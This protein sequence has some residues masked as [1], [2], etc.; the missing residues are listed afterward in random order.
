M[1]CGS[2]SC[3]LLTTPERTLPQNHH[4]RMLRIATT[5]TISFLFAAASVTAEEAACVL[6][7]HG[8]SLPEGLAGCAQQE[9]NGLVKLSHYITMTY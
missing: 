6:Y 5:A 1:Y 4:F 3:I 9:S 8:G 2:V 7:H